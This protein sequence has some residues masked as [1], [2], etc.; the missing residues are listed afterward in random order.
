MQFS[1]IGVGAVA[2]GALTLDGPVRFPDLP[3]GQALEVG[4]IAQ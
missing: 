4:V 2:V 3:A 1:A